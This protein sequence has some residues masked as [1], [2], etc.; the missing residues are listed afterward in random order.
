MLQFVGNP[1]DSARFMGPD[2]RRA[3]SN[4]M[5]EETTPVRASANTVTVPGDPPV[6]P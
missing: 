3:N 5:F 6:I 2:I 4:G 1:A